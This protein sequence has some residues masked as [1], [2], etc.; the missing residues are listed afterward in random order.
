[1][2]GAYPVTIGL[3]LIFLSSMGSVVWNFLAKRSLNKQIFLSLTITGAM[4]TMFCVNVVGI[5]TGLIP[6]DLPRRFLLFVVVDAALLVT[7]FTALARAYR[8]GEMSVVF[9]LWRLF[10]L[11]VYLFSV[12]VVGDRI[13][14]VSSIGVFV[15]VFGAYVLTLRE[16]SLPEVVRPFRVLL[17]PTYRLALLASLS[18]AA[19]VLLQKSIV[20]GMSPFLYNVFLQGFA[21]IFMF[22]V[23]RVVYRQLPALLKREWQTNRSAILTVA[24]VGPLTLLFSLYALSYIPASSAAA[25]SQISIVLGTATGILLLRERENLRIKAVSSSLITIGIALIVFGGG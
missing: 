18:T 7:S 20:P 11:F 5:A 3:L 10:P 19:S 6:T 16:V 22:V 2:N 9:P 23:N 17:K 4:I 25:F 8:E 12:G 24:C 21:S 14:V 1:M 13:G 15:S